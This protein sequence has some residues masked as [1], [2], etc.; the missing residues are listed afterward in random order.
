MTQLGTF[1]LLL[2]KLKD[3]SN[4]AAL[5][6]EGKIDSLL[7]EQSN[8]AIELHITSLMRVIG[9]LVF[10]VKKMSEITILTN[11][12]D[13]YQQ[14]ELGP[15]AAKPTQKPESCETQVINLGAS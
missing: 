9:L 14:K 8:D 1:L 2:S 5:V 7:R 6:N 13:S 3:S 12:I 11:L 4:L 15:Q 10:R